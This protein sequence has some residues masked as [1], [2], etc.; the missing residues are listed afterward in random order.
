MIVRLCIIRAVTLS[1]TVREFTEIK[2]EISG[3]VI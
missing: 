1:I 3:N 2:I